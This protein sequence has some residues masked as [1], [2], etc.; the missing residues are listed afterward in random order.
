[1]GGPLFRTTLAAGRAVGILMDTVMI[2]S[3]VFD[4]LILII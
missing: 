3:L 1:M 4:Y 2:C